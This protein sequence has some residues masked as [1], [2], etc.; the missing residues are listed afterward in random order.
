[1]SLSLGNRVDESDVIQDCRH[2]P[3]IFY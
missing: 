3:R 1:M 2:L